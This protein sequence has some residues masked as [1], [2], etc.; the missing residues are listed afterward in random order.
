[1]S[2]LSLQTNPT[3]PANVVENGEYAW[4]RK[5]SLHQFQSTVFHVYDHRKGHFSLELIEKFFP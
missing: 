3:V 1:M 5:I 2:S 4:R